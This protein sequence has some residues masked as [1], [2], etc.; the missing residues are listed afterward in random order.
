MQTRAKPKTAPSNEV[1]ASIFCADAIGTSKS[2][3]A[4]GIDGDFDSYRLINS[5]QLRKILPAS[6]MSIWRWERQGI[7]PKHF[8]IG[9]R[10]YW[11]LKKI[12]EVIELRS[13]LNAV[14]IG[15]D[16]NER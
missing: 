8:N 10:K 11:R 3:R 15:S 14:D 1:H 9:G 7:L 6:Q 16:E 5:A 2:P 12:L 4:P 13:G